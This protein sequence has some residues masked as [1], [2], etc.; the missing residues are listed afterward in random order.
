MVLVKRLDDA[1]RDRNPIRAIVRSTASSC[2][3]RT[4]GITMPS[5]E[6]HEALIRDCYHQCE[7]DH[8]IGK[9][10]FFECHATGTAGG[11]PVETT[12]VANVFGEHGGIHIGSIKACSIL[13]SCL[14]L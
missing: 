11:D 12:A 5:T 9:T 3:G 6:A 8:E 1:I 13:A 14:V 2:D 4:A 7:L 10:A